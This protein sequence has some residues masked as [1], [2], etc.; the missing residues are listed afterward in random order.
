[1]LTPVSEIFRIEWRGSFRIFDAQKLRICAENPC[2]FGKATG[3]VSLAGRLGNDSIFGGNGTDWASYAAADGA[4]TVDLNGGLQLAFG[5]DDN[6]TLSSI[7]NVQGGN[8]AGLLIGDSLANSLEG[9]IGADKLVA[10]LVMIQSAVGPTVSAI[11]QSTSW[12]LMKLL[13]N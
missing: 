2:I 12:R 6:D 9:G 4:V 7:E 11:L 3:A 8:S 10:G 1:M 5:A 13:L